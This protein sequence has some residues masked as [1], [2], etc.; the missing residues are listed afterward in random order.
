MKPIHAFAAALVS[1]L[2]A[3]PAAAQYQAQFATSDSAIKYRQGAF[4]V[5]AQ[6]FSRVAMMAQG[7][8]PFDA[9]SA[10][11]N[12][13]LV[14]SLSKLPFAAFGPGTD[15]GVPNRAKAEIWKEPVKFKAASD[16]MVADVAKLD[17]AA[18]TGNIEALKAAVGAVGQSCKSCH[19]DFRNSQKSVD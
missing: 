16:R 12:A 19:D 1:A 6:H 3:F 2:A 18:K 13:E 11:D 17:A 14:N 7:I 9:K 5:M 10:Q 15:K 8:Q 4:S